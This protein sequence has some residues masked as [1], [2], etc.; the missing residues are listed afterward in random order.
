[1][2]D[3]PRIPPSFVPT[4]TEV[5]AEPA[6]PNTQLLP[7]EPAGLVFPV[8]EALPD[9]PPVLEPL[10]DFAPLQSALTLNESE[11]AQAVERALPL[12]LAQVLQ[13]RGGDWLA[14]WSQALVQELRQPLIDAVRLQL[15]QADAHR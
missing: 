5:L 8:L 7:T 6:A 11:L 3:S 2:S 15:L 1:M 9:S 4:L 12:C 14:Q 13:A 10:L